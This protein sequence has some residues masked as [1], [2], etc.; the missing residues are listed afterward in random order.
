MHT[1][2]L[3]LFLHAVVKCYISRDFVPTLIRSERNPCK[4]GCDNTSAEVEGVKYIIHTMI[5]F[6]II[7]INF[8]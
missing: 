3:K 5:T 1:K 4:W 2:I 8:V 6:E 7:T